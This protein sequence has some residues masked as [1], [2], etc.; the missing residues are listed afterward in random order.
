[1]TDVIKIGKRAFTWSVVATTILWSIGA[2]ALV[3]LV[4]HAEEACI[5]L[6]KGDLFKVADNTA[7]YLINADMKRLYFPKSEIYHSWYEDFSGVTVISTACTDA[8]PAPDDAPFGVNYRAGSKLVKVQ[9]SPSVYVVEPNNT[10]RKLGSEAIAASLYG[11]NWAGLVRDINDVYWPNYDEGT[12]IAAAALHNGMLA[13]VAG[14]SDV[15]NVAGGKRYKVEGTLGS[16]VSGDVRTVTQA[17][18]DAVENGGTTVTPASMVS[19]P[20]Q[21]VATPTTP[22]T[23][24]TTTTTTQT[25]S[26]TLSV[27]LAADTPAA[28]NIVVSDTN[29]DNID[30]SG[31][32][33]LA[34][35]NFTATG[36]DVKVT[37]V[38]VKQ[39]GIN[40]SND[41]STLYLYDGNTYIAQH[42]SLTEKVF[43]FEATAGL[44][45]VT[46]GQTKTITVKADLSDNLNGGNTLYAQIV[47]ATDVESS[48]ASTTTMSAPLSGNSMS[49]I[50]VTD[51]GRAAITN[52]SPSGDTTV[53][54]GTTN[55]SVWSFQIQG[56]NNKLRVDRLKLTQ[57]GSIAKS[58]LGNLKLYKA[59]V[60]VGSTVD[61]LS[62]DNTA[63]FSGLN[64]E[65]GKGEA[66]TLELRAD[67]LSGTGRNF[68]FML[69]NIYDVDIVDTVYGTT[70][71]PDNNTEATWTVRY[72]GNDS[73]YETT[74]NSGSLTITVSTSTPTASVAT[75]A[76][77]IEV[78]KYD[79]KAVGEDIK[80]NDIYFRINSTGDEVGID[81]VAMYVEGSQVGVTQ[82][83]TEDNTA[84]QWTFGSSFI[85]PAGKTYVLSVKADMKNAASTNL[86]AGSQLTP[87]LNSTAGSATGQTS[88]T[89]LSL[90][91]AVAASVRT[92]SSGELAVV[93]NNEMVNGTASNPTGVTNESDI[94]IASYIVT[95][96]AAEAVTLS[97][98]VV[99]DDGA[100][101]YQLGDV[102]Y[103]LYIKFAGTEVGTTQSALDSAG[104]DG[105]YTFTPS[106]AISLTAGT[107]AVLN[108]YASVLSG[109]SITTAEAVVD[110]DSVSYYRTISKSSA[111]Y[112][113]DVV[114]QSIYVSAGGSLTVAAASTDQAAHI[115]AMGTAS[116]DRVELA[117][118]SLR[119]LDEDV[120][121]ESLIVFDQISVQGANTANVTSSMTSFGLYLDGQT[122]PVNGLE[123]NLTA[124]NTPNANT[125]YAVFSLNPKLTIAKG[126]TVNIAVKAK[127]NTYLNSSAGATHRISLDSAVE[128]LIGQTGAILARGAKSNLAINAPSSD[129][130]SKQHVLY[131][132]KPSVTRAD[133]PAGTKLSSGSTITLAD[134]TVTASPMQASLK[135]MTFSVSL[136]DTTTTTGVLTLDDFALYKDN[137]LLVAGTDV[138]IYDGSGTATADR[139]DTGGTGCI[140]TDSFDSGC[141]TT[142]VAPTSG[143]ST[144]V[145]IFATE[146]KVST[147]GANYKLKAKVSNV[148]TATADSDGVVV[149]L[150]SD[151]SATPSG[152]GTGIA[153][154]YNM[155]YLDNLPGNF[156]G[157]TASYVIGL[158][159]AAS[160]AGT[161]YEG[162]FI[163]SDESAASH[164]YSTN[165]ADGASYASTQ[166]Q[167]WVAGYLVGGLNQS[168]S[169]SANK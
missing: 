151:D 148:G 136:V 16:I 142:T 131:R 134:L 59:G 26:G 14:S 156:Y 80:V 102:F 11:A 97:S 126:T 3:P 23:T 112:S 82:D 137:S 122:S 20:S 69:Q 67:V 100:G 144:V 8:Y 113:T 12:A 61:A 38:K 21:G 27:A 88:Q 66:L 105:S 147:A 149:E 57:A 64:L 89:A 163:W 159:T 106:T 166:T 54:P 117:K 168:F 85:I 53:N 138:F 140:H 79:F 129:V 152:G 76:T 119:A 37:K 120:N 7:V 30:S 18:L 139:L 127:P 141:A 36:G 99:K 116:T 77:N 17:L 56:A 19:N 78:A 50:A 52:V 74:I 107:T 83:L 146:D 4:A 72:Q 28:G 123:V 62:S 167:E 118:F 10:I 125:G 75:G 70:L 9:I 98:F 133:L 40:G 65:I 165:L 73:G 91:S 49:Y 84:R 103:N 51:M 29:S 153:I 55:Y 39:A 109:Q 155:Y 34:K 6:E 90:S 145:V 58:D 111:T 154:T 92:I 135:K 42:K 45:T 143:T 101:T 108:V 114:G 128:S 24:T 96:P 43:S 2:A 1:M 124:T 68:R 169:W 161:A 46:S 5:A 110:L 157:G 87:T 31:R 47:S 71:Q 95:A 104:E 150:L 115:V 160:G 44:F 81:N 41:I 164:A 15:W 32:V 121:I 25:A 35:L 94:K 130:A 13:K 132:T 22:T 162:H 33:A 158:N 93:A 63:E 86:T 48:G 60:Q